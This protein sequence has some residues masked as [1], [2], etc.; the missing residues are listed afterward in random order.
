MHD[1]TGMGLD[2]CHHVPTTYAQVVYKNGCQAIG[3]IHSFRQLFYLPSCPLLKTPGQRLTSKWMIVL[4]THLTV[5]RPTSSQTCPHRS[6]LRHRWR[7]PR[8]KVA[9]YNRSFEPRSFDT[10]FFQLR[11]NRGRVASNILSW[12]PTSPR[13]SNKLSVSS[14]N[15]I[16][17]WQLLTA[18][19]L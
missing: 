1:V 14:L 16:G 4:P 15:Q 5:L 12:N 3:C 7:L 9:N 6:C 2:W 19:Q 13:S 18:D 17:L 10:C 8:S 11:R